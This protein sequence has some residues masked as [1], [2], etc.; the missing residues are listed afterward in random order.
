[1]VAVTR[2]ARRPPM[3][4]SDL[5]HG[6]RR[7][8]RLL[9]GLLRLIGVV[10]LVLV[11]FAV[12]V[13]AAGILYL[14]RPHI[15]SIGPGIGDALPLD[16]L[17]RRGSVPIFVFLA[18]WALAGALLG[19]VA[20]LLRAERLWSALL[21]ALTVGLWTYLQTGVSILVVRQIAAHAA[22]H[23]AG[24][25]RA[26]YVPTL[27]AA[28][29]GAVFARPR[30]SARPRAPR[31][32]AWFVGA[33][34]LAGVGAALLP[35]HH[36]N[37]IAQFAP[38]RVRPLG[39]AVV[40][41]L[42]LALLVLAPR[43]SRR[44]RRAWQLAVVL[45]VTLSLLH[46]VYD[47]SEQALA[48]AA[49]LVALVAR[50]HDFDLPG[51]P[52]AR[53]R[54]FARLTL[55]LLGLFGFGLVAVWTNRLDADQPFSVAFALRETSRALA[56]LSLHGSKHLSGSFGTWFPSAMLI[57]GIAAAVWVAS[58]WLAPWRYRHRQ[59]PAERAQAE[60]LVA[61]QADDTLAPFTLRRDKSYFFATSGRAFLAYRVVGGIAV[62]SG[63]PIGPTHELPNLLERFITFAHVR[64]WRI[65]VLGVGEDRLPLYRSLGLRALYH[66]DEAIVE[67]ES[68][69]LEGRAIRKVRQS[70]GRLERLGYSTEIRYAEDI[71]PA[72]RQ[73]LEAIA[74]AWRGDE[75]ERGFVMELDSFFTLTGREALFVIGCDPGGRAV[76]FLHFTVCRQASALSLS[77]MPRRRDTPNGFNEWLIC[78]ALAWAKTNGFDRVSLNFAPFAALLD[79]AARRSPL[80]EFERR[81][82]LHLKGRFQ[83]D[84]LLLFNRKF[85]P[86]WKRRFIVFEQLR[87][88][89]RVGIAALAAE[90]YLPFAW[91][92]RPNTSAAQAIPLHG[93]RES[94]SERS[95]SDRRR[96]GPMLAVA[97]CLIAG[98]FAVV[99]GIGAERYVINYWLYRGFPPP[100]D[101][102]WVTQ[103]GTAMRF[104]LPSPALRGRSQEVDVYLPPGYSANPSRRYPVFYLL[105]GSP[106]RPTA[107]LLTVR[108]GVLEDVL[109]AEQRMQPLILVMPFGSTG[110]FTDKEWANGVRP[111]ERWETFMVR[112][113]I[114]AIDRRYRTIRAAGARAIGGLSEGGYG[115]INIALHHPS[116]FH[117]VESWSGYE[118]ADPLRSIFDDNSALLTYNSPLVQLPR[119][120]QPLRRANTFF[121]FYSGKDDHFRLQ[122]TAFAHELR[123]EKINHI[124]FEPSGGHNWAIWR[125]EAGRALIA[126]ASHLR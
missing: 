49:V 106:G 3:R 120:A 27:L 99:G 103:R 5:P 92:L 37:A 32:L 44:R 107:F 53:P 116:L 40:A 123:R 72:L 91:P 2:P 25:L 10:G 100:H 58:A 66:G 51:D 68:F 24:R 57:G 9:P 121:W 87:D 126:A 82:L 73:E 48:A 101:P 84:N 63:D 22:F 31:I 18:V 54:A 28:V 13:L 67:T 108:V 45:L 114:A 88:L 17:S 118:R 77:S 86:R 36:T 69:S 16:E 117:V 46:L 105:H 98:S 79:P 47:F 111:N 55:S 42:A 12:V 96:A 41:P 60:T 81:V 8:R 50:R 74:T 59:E 7:L 62:V 29:G 95:G 119:A 75:P 21:L 93:E 113:V 89:P 61:E 122:N 64:D 33:A 52:A 76:G 78:A 112:D 71:D 38:E 115:A 80:Q 15:G 23:D 11:S 104:N 26:V 102:A 4:G 83:L 20:R 6:R 94:K 14:V 34:G 125:A 30:R 124:Y 90:N 39:H 70:T 19:L 110:T 85:L 97:V 109:V 56:G 65:A 35:V 43:L 1:M